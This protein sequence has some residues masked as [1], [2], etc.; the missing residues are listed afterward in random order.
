MWEATILIYRGKIDEKALIKKKIYN[1]RV[2]RE[3]KRKQYNEF[4]RY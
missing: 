4:G 3:A 1:K 2:R